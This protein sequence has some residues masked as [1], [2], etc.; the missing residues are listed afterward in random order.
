[1]NEQPLPVYEPLRNRTLGSYLKQQEAARQNPA[2]FVELTNRGATRNLPVSEHLAQKLT[3]AV[4]SIYGDGYRAQVYSGGQPNIGSGGARVGSTRHD[5]GNAADVYIVA[6]DGKRLSGDALAPLAKH[7]LGNKYGGVGLEMKGG[8]I[9]LDTHTDRAPFWKYGAITPAQQAAVDEGL[10]AWGKAPLSPPGAF[11]AK[12]AIESARQSGA[13]AQAPSYAP[14]SPP[15]NP[16][17][18]PA[19]M[20]GATVAGADGS[21]LYY[22]GELRDPSN[23][24]G[25]IANYATREK[26]MGL[27]EGFG[28]NMSGA[29]QQNQAVQGDPLAELFAQFFGPAEENPRAALLK[30]NS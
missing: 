14:A 4:Q 8:G 17:A 1:M 3:S 2:N 10:A 25:S 29:G 26:A 23:P 11:A 28:Q 7:W 21:P 27:L 16:V 6:P 15:S 20:A 13:M 5:G 22:Q 30:G 24:G 9:H 18:S 12:P 19:M